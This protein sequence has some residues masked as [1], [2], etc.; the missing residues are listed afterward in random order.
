MLAVRLIQTLALLILLLGQAQ[1]PQNLLAET[2][3]SFSVTDPKWI[4]NDG[5]KPNLPAGAMLSVALAL[6]GGAQA[7]WLDLVLSSDEQIVLL[8]N[9]RIDTLTNVAEV[10]P[11]RSRPDGSYYAFDFT[12]AELRQLS[13]RHA[14][15]TPASPLSQAL[16][17]PIFPVI[18]L[19]DILGYIELVSE[20]FEAPATLIC[21]IKQGWLHER[22]GK[23]LGG[24][25]LQALESYQDAS[26]KAQLFLA[27]YDPEELQQ[28]A[29][30]RVSGSPN[31]IDFIQLVGTNDGKEVQ[32]LEFGSYQPYNYDL[33]FT[34]F[35]LKSV[36]AYATVIGLDAP[37]I[38][39]E[40]GSVLMPGFLEDART[41]GMKI[42]CCRPDSA[43]FIPANGDSSDEARLEHLLFKT[44]FDGI[45]TGQDAF[46]RNWLL[47]RRE[48]AASEQQ[49]KIERLI[50]QIE[51]SGL[52]PSDFYQSDPTR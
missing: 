28:L 37:A 21:A 45:V 5:S 51:D 9:A 8:A 33:L 32:R 2:P 10:Y 48:G 29:S 41:L 19:A 24:L 14:Q 43:S 52:A 22:E 23:N 42:I 6:E 27:S 31:Q 15:G 47:N 39:D 34:R 36:S 17:K 25:V 38:I 13:H 4:I 7:V 18:S 44:G 26:G 46:A 11:D 3:G 12:L 30:N 40:S 20:N 49:K 35:G 50:D 1:N 16:F